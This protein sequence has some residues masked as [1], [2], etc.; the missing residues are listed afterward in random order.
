MRNVDFYINDF[1]L[2]Y[3]IKRYKQ[4][5]ETID[6]FLGDFFI[7]KCMWSTPASI[8]STVTSIKKFYKCMLD[9]QNIKKDDYG[10][11]CYLIKEKYG[12]LAVHLFILQ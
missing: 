5:I 3:D 8:K 1:P 7:R 2:Y 6:D 9:H 11:L 12:H 10:K 4:G